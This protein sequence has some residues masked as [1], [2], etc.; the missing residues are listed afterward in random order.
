MQHSFKVEK[1]ECDSYIQNNFQF[2]Q[3]FINLENNNDILRLN[4]IN[5]S[6]CQNNQISNISPDSNISE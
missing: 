5:S 4:I 1:A 3:N 6:T 2:K